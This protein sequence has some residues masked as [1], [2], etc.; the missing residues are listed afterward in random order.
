MYMYIYIYI[1]GQ[2]LTVTDAFDCLV[3]YIDY[4]IIVCTRLQHVILCSVVSYYDSLYWA[5]IYCDII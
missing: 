3:D 4:I 1:L 2:R 5:M